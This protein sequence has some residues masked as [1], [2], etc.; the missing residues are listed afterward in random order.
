MGI[1]VRLILLL[2]FINLEA[3][4]ISYSGGSTAMLIT[5]NMKDSVYYHY[6]PTYKYSVGI[7]TVKDLIFDQEY[8]YL[9]FTYLMN[10]KN[11]RNSQRNLYFQSGISSKGRDNVFYGI[12]GDWET[13][14]VF[15]GFGFKEVENTTQDYQDYFLQAGIAPYIGEYGDLHTWLML[16]SKKNTLTNEWQTYPVLKF[17]KGDF[18]IEFGYDSKINWDVHMMYRF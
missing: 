2:S 17:F 6:S 8:S 14:R 13:R 3:R 1:L 15:T 4:P 9:R 18:L 12:H 5:D 10:R 16:K 11:T 7:E